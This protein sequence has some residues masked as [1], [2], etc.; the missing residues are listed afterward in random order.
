[1][2][3]SSS[4]P[5]EEAF[6]GIIMS[7][8]TKVT[9][10]SW[11]A[12]A[13]VLAASLLCHY[14][15]PLDHLSRMLPKLFSSSFEDL[16][17]VPVIFA[18]STTLDRLRYRNAVRKTWKKAVDDARFFFVAPERPCLVDPYWRLTESGCRL[19]TVFVPVN[20]NDGLP[21]R[22][23]RVQPSRVAPAPPAEGVGFSLK[24]PV[25][26]LQFGV[27]AKALR[28]F[29]NSNLTVELADP[30]TGD[31]HLAVNFSAADL[32]SSSGDDG[33]VY[34]P[35][36][37]EETFS[38]GFE[39]VL[40]INQW[41]GLN[42]SS[43]HCN[44]VWN[45]MFGDDGVVPFSFLWRQGRSQ[46][47]TPSVCPLV[48]LV[49]RVP[50]MGELRQVANARDTQNKCQANKVRQTQAKLVEE[51][52]DH[53]DLFL[54][55]EVI[56]A[57]EN[58]PLALL[59]FFRHILNEFNFD[60]VVVANDETFMAADRLTQKL[61][62]PSSADDFFPSSEFSW[63]GRFK[64]EQPVRHYG[65]EHSD[66]AYTG[67]AYPAVPADS[68]SV[69]S[70]ALVEALVNSHFDAKKKHNLLATFGTLAH[71]LSVWLAPFAPTLIED[72]TF[73]D[74]N[75]TCN[76]SDFLAFGPVKRDMSSL[77]LNY[78][79]CGHICSCSKQ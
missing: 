23:F 71:S 50:D 49:F 29:G 36:K 53:E 70:R 64:R 15:G 39:A 67:A 33:F 13:V 78:V 22:P 14:C 5:G 10:L 52:E 68:G 62:P 65:G 20:V 74:G 24:F 21:V 17:R 37:S 60:F 6:S 1:M 19:W 51:I 79:K 26:V 30:A 72:G 32:K 66:P 12:A 16:T 41:K 31:Q 59:T 34:T 55:P 40:R 7:L 45:K 56:D 18:V 8:S 58:T 47:F 75:A 73:S 63:R 3:F 46:P 38:R 25:S 77:W 42:Y 69:L 2:A 76:D 35:V 43:L 28:Q 57:P 11:L 27:S 44:I 48:S 54:A 9:T 4:P 61:A